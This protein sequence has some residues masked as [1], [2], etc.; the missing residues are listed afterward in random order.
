MTLAYSGFS[1]GLHNK[2][3]L[4]LINV[5]SSEDRKNLNVVNRKK[6][7]SSIPVTEYVYLY[8][9]ITSAK[10]AELCV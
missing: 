6:D 1:T 4:T 2:K 3:C 10:I 8:C 7:S 5:T 9:T